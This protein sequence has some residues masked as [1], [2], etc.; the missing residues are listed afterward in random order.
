ML[1]LHT[2]MRP[3]IERD[4]MASPVYSTANPV[5]PAVPIFPIIAK[6][7]SLAVT[8]SETDP[9]TLISIVLGLNC[10]NV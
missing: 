5:A 4:V 8:P 9:S 10:L 6:I 2:V 7:I 1:I 3:S